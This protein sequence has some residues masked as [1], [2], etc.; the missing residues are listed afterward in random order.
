MR[1]PAYSRFGIALV[2][3]TLCKAIVVTVLLMLARAVIYTAF[4][5]MVGSLDGNTLNASS[6][7]SRG[8]NWLCVRGVSP[9]YPS[10]KP[11]L[12]VLIP[13]TRM[14]RQWA[15]EFC[16]GAALWIV[17][18]VLLTQLLFVRVHRSDGGE[19][20]CRRCGYILKGLSE[21]RCPECGEGI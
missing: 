17:L 20:V 2:R 8:G 10:P 11:S 6:G 3:S 7:P 13:T 14:G 19:S 21:P 9:L 16:A 18:A 15:G 1:K 4:G 5:I 12:L